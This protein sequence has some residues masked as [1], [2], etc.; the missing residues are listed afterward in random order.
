MFHFNAFIRIVFSSL[1]FLPLMI[2][3]YFIINF[4]SSFDSDCFSSYSKNKPNTP[5]MNIA[6]PDN[7][8]V[9][10]WFDGS[11]FGRNLE[12]IVHSMN[13]YHVPGGIVLNNG[14]SCSAQFLSIKQ[15][16]A[17]NLQG[18]E[19]IESSA[20]K[21]Y[22]GQKINNMPVL[23]PKKMV[24]YD[25]SSNKGDALL[26]KAMN[27]TKKRNGWII[28]YFHSNE[29]AQQKSTFNAS[30]LGH[31]LRMI[32]RLG[33]PVVLKEQVLKVSA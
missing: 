26:S 9:T 24:F 12:N 28:L 1:M 6:W 5:V 10:L 19:I 11:F 32:K 15:L 13:Q 20:K 25:M 14:R 4:S 29:S 21:Q 2:L 30:Q 7:G 31:T 17:M 16:H 18:W 23:D 22:V 33:M 3:V 27:K 8:L